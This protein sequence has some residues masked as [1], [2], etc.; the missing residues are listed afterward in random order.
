VWNH[1]QLNSLYLKIY[2][3]V[4][5]L[6]LQFAEPTHYDIGKSENV[7]EI[8]QDAAEIDGTP[9]DQETR[10]IMLVNDRITLA[11]GARLP[12]KVEVGIC[13][14]MRSDPSQ[15]LTVFVEDW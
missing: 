12:T 2:Y 6:H 10:G 5:W 15:D 8:Q 7:Q 3:H 11:T 9:I 4:D 1:S 13:S 14:N